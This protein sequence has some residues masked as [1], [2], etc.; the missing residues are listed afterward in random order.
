MYQALG[1]DVPKVADVPMI[2]GIGEGTPEQ[3]SRGHLRYGL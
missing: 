2:L 1:F 3:T